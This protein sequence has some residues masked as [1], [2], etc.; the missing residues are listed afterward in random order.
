MGE[1]TTILDAATESFLDQNFHMAQVGRC[2]DGVAHDLNN[3]LGAVLAYAELISTEEGV[4]PNVRR[5]LDECSGA[6]RK[7]THLVATLTMLAR[8]SRETMVH[9]D[10]GP[11]AERV[12]AMRQYDM[13]LHK[14]H[15]RFSSEGAT[16]PVTMNQSSI[17]MA[18]V[19]LITHCI[20][21]VTGTEGREITLS[22]SG[23]SDRV[24][25]FVWNSGPPIDA[26]ERAHLFDGGRTADG[27]SCMEPGLAHARGFI[28]KHGGTLDYDASRGF[29]AR[30]PKSK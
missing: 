2:V 24:E 15:G 21:R 8:P 30:L 23:F 4:D 12:F 7:A 13:R 6:L 9:G 27:G 26:D 14:I 10:V 11:L 29:I 19:H 28:E 20:E 1:P 18:L 25:V 22:V 17:A 5:M 3:Y 16:G